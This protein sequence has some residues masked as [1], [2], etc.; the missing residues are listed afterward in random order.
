MSKGSRRRPGKP[1]AYERG[2]EAINW[3]KGRPVRRVTKLTTQET[4]TKDYTDKADWVILPLEDL[5]G[6]SYAKRG[7]TLSS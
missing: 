1:G 6:P 5:L 3:A 7:R 4:L 2:Y